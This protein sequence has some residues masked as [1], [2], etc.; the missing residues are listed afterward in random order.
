L[1]IRKFVNFSFCKSANLYILAFANL[2]ICT[3]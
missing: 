1:Q 3:I 2:Q